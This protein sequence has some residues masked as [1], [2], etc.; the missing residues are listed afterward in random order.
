MTLVGGSIVPDM[1]NAIV[2]WFAGLPGKVLAFISQLVS[3]AIATVSGWAASMIAKF[4]EMVSKSVE[5][6]AG[7]PA[8]IKS[9]MS[10][11]ATWLISA[12][13]QT[14]S[15]MQNGM[16]TGWNTA[17]GWLNGIGGRVT[18]AVGSLGSVLR[19]AGEAA[20]NGLK[21]GMQ[22]VWDNAV[23]GWLASLAGKIK[24]LKG[25]IQKD[26]TM[27]VGEGKAIITGLG[28]GLQA[29]WSGVQGQLKS[30][31]TELAGAF[32]GGGSGGFSAAYTMEKKQEIVHKVEFGK[33][34]EGLTIDMTGRE[35][36][37]LLVGDK[38]ALTDVARQV[39]VTNE[40]DI[41]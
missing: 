13:T 2:A 29:A 23:S 28:T 9:A 41:R 5:W 34:P 15:G 27:L 26:R 19:G 31:N 25:P 12:G 4:S 17:S 32:S 20:L 38:T 36:A 22:S 14:L 6:V 35:I 16:T 39:K 33:L 3:S 8:K 1:I 40:K 10:G 24:A 30:Y 7:L 21:S 11:A 18:S 37:A